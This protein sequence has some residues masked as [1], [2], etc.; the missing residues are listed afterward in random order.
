MAGS[1]AR[2][3]VAPGPPAAAHAT[4][5]S[6]STRIV[7]RLGCS[8][9]RPGLPDGRR[10]AGFS[11]P[12]PRAVVPPPALPTRSG[13]SG[14]RHLGGGCGRRDAGNLAPGTQ[15]RCRAARAARRRAMD[16]RGKG[17]TDDALQLPAPPAGEPYEARYSW[18]RPPSKPAPSPTSASPSSSAIPR[19]WPPL[20]P[21]E[22]LERPGHSWSAIGRVAG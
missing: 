21:G 17:L 19:P 3:A 4:L 9:T 10:A 14:Q 5:I 11:A 22:G 1:A 16:P 18:T 7:G 12:V 13:S 15:S 20:P 8:A 2:Q 6:S